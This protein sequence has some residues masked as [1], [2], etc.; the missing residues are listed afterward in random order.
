MQQQQRISCPQEE[1]KGIPEAQIKP[2]AM[3]SL[4]NNVQKQVTGADISAAALFKASSSLPAGP[5]TFATIFDIYKYANTL[6]GVE[7]TGAQLKNYMERQAAYYNQY[8]AGD[9]TV[10]FN[11]IFACTTTTCFLELTIKLTFRNQ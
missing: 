3:I 7:I 4:I 5:V 1:V 10:S 9:V 6:V 8:Q 11:E 2:T